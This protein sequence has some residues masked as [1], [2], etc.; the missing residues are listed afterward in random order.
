MG[1]ANSM[2]IIIIVLQFKYTCVFSKPSLL[3]L[4]DPKSAT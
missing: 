2:N 1:V 3:T 4:R